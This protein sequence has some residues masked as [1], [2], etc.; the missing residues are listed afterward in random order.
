MFKGSEAR[1]FL[2]C[3]FKALRA[4]VF[5][6]SGFRVASVAVSG[7]AVFRCLVFC[8]FRVWLGT[9]LNQ[10]PVLGFPIIR[11]PYCI[12]EPKRDP[13]LESYADVGYVKGKGASP[14]QPQ[15]PP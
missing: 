4:S 11:V 10:G 13:N 9:S 12:G 14:L 3:G 1:G 15:A 6:G 5:W 8:R 7:S 2:F